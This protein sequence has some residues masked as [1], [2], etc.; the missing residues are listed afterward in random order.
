MAREDM[1]PG[2]VVPP[3]IPLKTI[4]ALS[5][6][7]IGSGRVVATC[8]ATEGKVTSCGKGNRMTW[9]TPSGY[10]GIKEA[11]KWGEAL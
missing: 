6:R 3:A 4:P 2:Q 7:R 5:M 9:I 1:L 8:C 10:L 11:N